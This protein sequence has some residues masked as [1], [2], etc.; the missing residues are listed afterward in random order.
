MTGVAGAALSLAMIA[1]VALIWG[2][3]RMIPVDRKRG[4]LMI[5]AA[6]VV[7]GN[8]LIMTL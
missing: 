5:A 6:L 1:V 7:L 3:V 8:V 2:G 4:I